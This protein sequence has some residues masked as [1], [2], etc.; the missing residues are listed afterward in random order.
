MSRAGY[1]S[2]L[3]VAPRVDKVVI[4]RTKGRLSASGIDKVGL[5]TST[6][7]KSGAERVQPLVCIPV[8]DDAILLIGSNYG[9][10]KHP[11]WSHNLIANPGCT[12][13]FRGGPRAFVA[14]MLEGDEYDR[15]WALAVDFYAGYA[16]Y[17]ANCAPRRIRIA[18]LDPAD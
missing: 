15:A 10:E 5:L 4:P 8:D 6:G 12:L 2:L 11:A 13:Q 16:N 18:R 3:H 9:R 14:R 17:K 7:A 1:W